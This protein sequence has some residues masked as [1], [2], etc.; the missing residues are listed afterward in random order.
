MY[1]KVRIDSDFDLPGHEVWQVL[2]DF[3]GHYMFNPLIEVSPITNG[4]TEGLG[5]EREIVMYDGSR[6]LQKVLDYE[7][8]RSMLVGF[9]ETDLPIRMGTARF[10]IDPVDQPFCNLSIEVTYEPKLG[11]VGGMLGWLYKPVV[12]YRYA[13]ILRGLKHFV[14]TGR[15]AGQPIG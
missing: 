1:L 15:E 13:M 5:A 14:R 8:A 7:E 2:K 4:I 6:M 11:L 9:L 3:G 12:R 10:A